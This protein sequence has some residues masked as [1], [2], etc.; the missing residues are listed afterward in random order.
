ML[1]SAP[2]AMGAKMHIIVVMVMANWFSTA[3]SDDVVGNNA[4]SWSNCNIPKRLRSWS[5]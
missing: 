4:L 3:E 2:A 1:T 5:L